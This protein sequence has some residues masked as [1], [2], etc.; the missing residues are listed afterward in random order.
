MGNLVVITIVASDPGTKSYGF[1]VV[2]FRQKGKQIQYRVVKTSK[3]QVTADIKNTD[4]QGQLK[5]YVKAFN[6]VVKSSG[7]KPTHLIAER[8]MARGLKGPLVESVNMMLGSLA[9]S[10]NLPIT[11]VPAVVWK[12]RVNKVFDLKAFYKEARIEPHELDATMM[13][14]FLAEK[15]FNQDIVSQLSKKKS[16]SNLI[17]VIEKCTTSKLKNKKALSVR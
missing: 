4:M 1:S 2:Q 3:L 5:A 17:K 8:F 12:N 11:F 13:A 9:Y 15:I 6:K 10:T 14:F 7:K 16:R